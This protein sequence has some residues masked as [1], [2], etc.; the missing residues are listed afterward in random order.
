MAGAISGRSGS[1]ATK[2]CAQ[3]AE[4]AVDMSLRNG[5]SPGWADMIQCKSTSLEMRSV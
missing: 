4:S 1:I 2:A 3:G 5:L